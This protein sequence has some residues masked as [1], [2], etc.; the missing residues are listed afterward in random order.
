MKQWVTFHGFALNVSTDLSYF[1]LI[2]PCGI[3][4][5]VMTSVSRELRQSGSSSL[6]T[7]TRQSVIEGVAH[8]LDLKPVE[9]SAHHILG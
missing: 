9:T 4:D 5:V 2:I 8:A 6:W 7:A 3:R 1:D